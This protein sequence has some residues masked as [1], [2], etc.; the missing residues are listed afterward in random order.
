M[1]FGHEVGTRLTL[2]MPFDVL[3]DEKPE[4]TET[5]ARI[6]SI[7]KNLSKTAPM[8]GSFAFGNDKEYTPLQATDLVAW[9]TTKHYLPHHPM[10]KKVL[11]TMAR[12]NRIVP[13]T[14]N[15][16]LIKGFVDISRRAKQQRA[17]S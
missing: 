10:I 3:F 2:P 7:F 1:L 17:K 11:E 15:E 4:F 12:K 13:M 6:A 8:M 14:L 9:D 16:D 5:A